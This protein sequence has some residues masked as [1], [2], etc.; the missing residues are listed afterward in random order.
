MPESSESLVA[1]G[2]AE[3]TGAR[4]TRN[5]SDNHLLAHTRH[6]LGSMPRGVRPVHLQAD[7]P[8]IANDLSRLR[9]ETAA[10]DHYFE[11]L[12][13]SARANRT[14]F[15]PVIKEELL[16][17]HLLSL[18]NRTGPYKGRAP[19]RVSLLSKPRDASMPS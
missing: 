4:R 8:R 9:A 11:K 1:P 7:F 14:G 18:S 19:Q 3:F 17:L 10:L 15:H 6:W 2:A 13:F 16:A 12:D 5:P